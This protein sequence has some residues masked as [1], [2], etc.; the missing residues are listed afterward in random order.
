[1]IGLKFGLGEKE[2]DSLSR[3]NIPAGAVANAWDLPY[4]TSQRLPPPPS[5]RMMKRPPEKPAESAKNL[6]K[7]WAVSRM[8]SLQQVICRF[9]NSVHL[10]SIGNASTE[11][12]AV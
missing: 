10:M 2:E 5:Q 3:E 11:T 4:V 12:L 6:Q 9:E 7:S 1:M 8:A